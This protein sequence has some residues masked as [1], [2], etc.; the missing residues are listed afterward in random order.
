MRHHNPSNVSQFSH[1][2]FPG[3]LNMPYQLN[4]VKSYR[5]NGFKNVT[6]K[7]AVVKILQFVADH[8][9]CTRAEINVG[10]YGFKSVESARKYG[11]GYNSAMYAQLL[12]LD[13]LDYDKSFR[14]HVTEKGLNVLKQSYI[15]DVIKNQFTK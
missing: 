3:H 10:V 13:L 14:Y 7:S 6:K 9:N 5:R 2:R 11:R 15:N 8:E 4:Y 12:Y 1:R